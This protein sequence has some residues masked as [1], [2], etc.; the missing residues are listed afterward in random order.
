M[1]RKGKR[2]RS[3]ADRK[4]RGSYESLESCVRESQ[5][6]LES[7]SMIVNDTQ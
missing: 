1:P 5:A 4:H 3:Q 2:S 6:L 7:H